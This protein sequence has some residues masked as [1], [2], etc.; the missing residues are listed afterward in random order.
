MGFKPNTNASWS[1]KLKFWFKI[2]DNKKK[3]VHLIAWSYLQQQ[4]CEQAATICIYIW[5]NKNSNVISPSLHYD[6]GLFL[7]KI[8]CNLT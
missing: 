1:N 5:N 7:F 2:S 6:E 8:H 4:F 3:W